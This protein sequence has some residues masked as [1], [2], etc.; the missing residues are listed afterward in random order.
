MDSETQFM[1]S[2]SYIV[3]YRESR[4]CSSCFN[5]KR[6]CA[7]ELH[8]GKSAGR[9]KG[10]GGPLPALHPATV[11]KSESVADIPETAPPSPML[12][13]TRWTCPREV[14][15]PCCSSPGCPRTTCFTG[16]LETDPETQGMEESD[17]RW[18][19]KQHFT[20][21]F[22]SCLIQLSEPFAWDR[23]HFVSVTCGQRSLD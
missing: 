17:S 13:G 21:L 23:L 4:N 15:G 19:V 3:F 11:M 20:Y 2:R 18:S 16:G 6:T 7:G 9:S 14:P 1:L 8:V 5:W 12:P 22:I 10:Q